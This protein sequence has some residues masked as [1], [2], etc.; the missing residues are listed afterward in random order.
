MTGESVDKSSDDMAYQPTI[1]DLISL[2]LPTQ[3][4]VSP[5]GR[6]VAYLVRTTNWNKNRYEN[7]CYVYDAA[8]ARSVRL[9]RSG[10][11]QQI[12][13]LDDETLAVAKTED[14]DKAQIWVFEHLAGEGVQVT[15][16]K[17]GVQSFMP[18]AEGLLFLA[19]QPERKERKP[20]ADEFGT[21]T[22]F[23]QEESA[24]ALYY[25][26]LKRLQ[27]Y[28]EQ[29]RQR[30]EDEAKELVEPVLELSRRLEQPLKVVSF[31]ASPLGDAIYL[32]CRSRDDLVYWEQTS[33]F[34]LKLDAEQALDEFVSRERARKQEQAGQPTTTQE[35]APDEDVSYIGALT[36]IALPKGAAIVAVSPQGAKLLVSHKARD[37]MFYTQED[38]WVLDLAE[39]EAALEDTSLAD[40]LRKI[41]GDLDQEVLRAQWTPGGIFASYPSGTRTEIARLSE[42][43]SHQV[44]A[45]RD[46]ERGLMPLWRFH[47]SQAGAL[48]FI[49]TDESTFPE[50]YMATPSSVTG[51]WE[52]KRLTALG[53]AVAGWELGN[54]ETVRWTSRDGT[55]IEGVLRKPADFDPS[56]K[57]PLVFVV[58]GGPSDSSS[59]VL[60]DIDDLAYYPAVQFCQRGVLVLKPNYRGSSGRGQ[61]FLE[62]NKDNL[63]V[64]D[65]EDLESAID[66]LDAQGFLDASRVGCMGWSQGGYISA[67]AGIH[68]ERF[69]AVS[70]G[71]GIADWYTYHIANDIPDFTTHYL[72]G[73]PF[74]DRE[75]YVK[76]APISKVQQAKT[77][78]LIQHGARDQRVPLANATELYRGLKDVGVPVELFVFPEMAHPIT[79]PRENRAVMWQNLTWFRHH[80][81][82]EK[83]DFFDVADERAA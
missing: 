59:T 25:V 56:R 19:E 33:S 71:A 64:G 73:T 42:S 15:D 12:E 1:T 50:V 68:S 32:N 44:L 55:E 18:F 74:K 7:V 41:T 34:C 38:L 83:L 26:S 43:G 39:A 21:F 82:G 45:L 80:L 9:T 16:H 49:G 61:A 8:R 40:R 75:L 69:R 30:T 48:G 77:P 13:W 67:F 22:H 3:V 10:D 4:R 54:V 5:G 78:T 24:S 23:E 31:V 37:N 47:A 53:E 6:R 57:Y 62:L 66:H 81:L 20:R 58:H 27:E 70:V 63:G 46:G 14:D 60:L 29:V 52:V 11:V 2:E 79:K 17:S 72:S 51:E 35:D 36:R 28:Q 65:L 76:T